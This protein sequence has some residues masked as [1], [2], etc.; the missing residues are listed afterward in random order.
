[1]NN[2][3]YTFLPEQ[4]D[5]A[6]IPDAKCPDHLR[7]FET[8]KPHLYR[9]ITEQFK[10]KYIAARDDIEIRKEIVENIGVSLHSYGFR[11]FTGKPEDKP[12]RKMELN[13]ILTMIDLRMTRLCNKKVPLPREVEENDENEDENDGEIG[14]FTA[15]GQPTSKCIVSGQGGKKRKANVFLQ[16]QLQ[17]KLNT[18]RTFSFAHEKTMIHIQ[19]RNNVH[20]AGYFFVSRDKQSGLWSRD[21]YKEA[22]EKIRNAFRHLLNPRQRI[23][24]EEDDDAIGPLTEDGRP[25]SKSI[26][27]GTHNRKAN[28]FVRACVMTR[29]QEYEHAQTTEQQCEI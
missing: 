29:M 3:Q 12:A 25:T 1:M 2:I 24:E 16:Q 8:T 18:Y 5:I 20:D 21:K 14:P 19:I 22:S 13:K 10:E 11:F 15:D 17:S 27:P 4:S 28:A 6:E 23:K 26:L 7:I 9:T